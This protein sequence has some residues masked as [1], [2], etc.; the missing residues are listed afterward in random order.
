MMQ[1]KKKELSEKYKRINKKDKI[2]LQYNITIM[3]RY[4]SD[5]IVFI[6]IYTNILIHNCI[7]VDMQQCV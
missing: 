7:Y 1:K 5:D 4:K 6:Y 2:Y 3:T